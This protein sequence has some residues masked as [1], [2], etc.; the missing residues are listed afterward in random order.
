VILK[1]KNS[2]TTNKDRFDKPEEIYDVC[3]GL[4][5]WMQGKTLMHF[6]KK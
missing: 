1:V 3:Q 6:E 2:T 5:W 4:G